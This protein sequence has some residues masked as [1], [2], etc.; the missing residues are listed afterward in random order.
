MTV[1]E[2]CNREVVYIGPE[3]SVGE[4]ARLM[5]SHHVGDLVVADG[6]GGQLRP[7][8]ILT[9]RDI[10]VE[11]VGED[12]PCDRVTV[13]DVMARDLLTAREDDDLLDTMRRMRERGVRRVPVV[14]PDNLLVGILTVDDLVDLLSEQLGNI[15]A[16]FGK[17]S[18]HE[19]QRRSG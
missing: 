1:G 6:G 17:A 8:G 16:L 19:R 3:A 13:A 5:R 2:I 12:V 18:R 10:V 15:V 9:D 11:V 7:I 14:D 4:A